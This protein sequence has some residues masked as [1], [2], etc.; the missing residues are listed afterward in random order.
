MQTQ[1]F[2]IVD[3]SNRLMAISDEGVSAEVLAGIRRG[4]QTAD[5]NGM[6]RARRRRLA[7]ILC[8]NPD[9]GLRFSHERK[10]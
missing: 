9:K 6:S 3:R 5:T 7:A 1:R 8:Q 4:A 2:L 10:Y